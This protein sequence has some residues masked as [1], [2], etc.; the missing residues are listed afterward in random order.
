MDQQETN[1]IPPVVVDLGAVKKKH[2]KRLRRGEGKLLPQ[3]DEVLAVLKEELSDE[4]GDRQLVPV[5]LV[6][7]QKD[8]P[9]P[10]FKF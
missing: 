6:Y 7:E 9:R 4:L 5:V 1:Q 3:I 10:L 8:K 2:I